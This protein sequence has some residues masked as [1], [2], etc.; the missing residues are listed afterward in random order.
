MKKTLT[1]LAAALLVLAPVWAKDDDKDLKVSRQEAKTA[2]RQA[3]DAEKLLRKEG[4]KSFEPGSVSSNLEKYFLKVNAG[5]GRIV[6]IST[7]CMSEN[8]AKLS[9][10]ANAANEY[11]VLQGGHIRGRIVSSASSLSG[12]QVDNLVASF[13]RLVEKDIRGELIPYATFYKEKGS[14]YSAR[15]YCIVDEEAA[16]AAR[17]HAMELALSEQ[18]LIDQYGTMVADWVGDGF[19]NKEDMQ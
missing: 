17:R 7:A 6:G 11:A 4:F 9:A 8:L 15:V 12:H 1:I 10:L 14:Q 18:A 3:R 19:K 5:C 16:A 2:A 13:E